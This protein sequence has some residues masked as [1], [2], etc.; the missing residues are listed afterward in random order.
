[1]TLE[2]KVKAAA[3]RAIRSQTKDKLNG[4]CRYYRFVYDYGF[5]NYDR[6]EKI[7]QVEYYIGQKKKT[8]SV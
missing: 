3:I 6:E 5:I 7:F 1:M 4:Y 2:E 8:L